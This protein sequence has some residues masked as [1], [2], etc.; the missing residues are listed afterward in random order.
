MDPIPYYFEP[1]N[2]NA[3]LVRPKQPFF[4]W[5]NAVYSDETPTTEKHEC[6]IY[7]IHEM[8]SNQAIAMWL[9]TNFED[10]FDNE[11]NDWCTDEDTWPPN[12]GS[13]MF[14]EW[15]DV[16]FHSMLLDLEDDP[17]LKDM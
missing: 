6:N 8:E 15:F 3:F 13:K 16:E 5:L 9:K 4:D 10:I 12:R 7:L 11:L 2:R 1:I 14:S 17:V